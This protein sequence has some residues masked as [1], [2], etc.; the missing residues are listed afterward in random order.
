VYVQGVKRWGFS[1]VTVE[2]KGNRELAWI[3]TITG[4]TKPNLRLL[5]NRRKKAGYVMF[6]S[7]G[8]GPIEVSRIRSTIQA[9]IDAGTPP[10]EAVYLGMGEVSKIY[11]LAMEKR[12]KQ[13]MKLTEYFLV[14]YFIGNGGRKIDPM[15]KFYGPPPSELDKPSNCTPIDRIG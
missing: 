1:R 10:T 11:D 8:L 5:L 12:K 9:H 4:L 13:F 14:K 7:F 3:C 15:E 6:V 2:S